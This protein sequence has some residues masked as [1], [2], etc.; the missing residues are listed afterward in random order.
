MVVGQTVGIFSRSGEVEYRW[1]SD[2]LS[3]F[4]TVTPFTITNSNF[5]AFCD[6]IYR[7]S[8]AILYHSRNRGRVNITDVTDSLY[9]EE[10]KLM[11][12]VLGKEHVIAVIDDL[13][14]SS[15]EA[16]NRILSHQHSLRVR[17]Q[18]IFL[19]TT[20]EKTNHNLLRRKVENIKS[21]IANG[22]TPMSIEDDDTPVS[23]SVPQD[24]MVVG[25]TVGIFSRSGEVEYRWLS[26]VLRG[27]W[28]VTPFTITN[29]NFPAFCDQI[30]RCSFAILYHSR[31]RGRVNITDVTDSLYDEEVTF[32]SEVLGKAHVIAVID[33]LDDSSD[34]AKHRILSHQHSLRVRTQDIFLVT[35]QEKANHNLLRRK[36]ENIR[37]AIANGL[38]PPPIEGPG[39]GPPQKKGAAM[40][41]AISALTILSFRNAYHAPNYRNGLLLIFWTSLTLKVLSFRVC[42]PVLPLG[43]RASLL[44][45]STMAVM[46]IY[47]TWHRPSA[48]HVTGSLLWIICCCKYFL[49]RRPSSGLVWRLIPYGPVLLTLWKMWQPSHVET[50]LQAISYFV[51]RSPLI[52]AAEGI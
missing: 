7:C 25:Q 19:V 38:R 2:V 15:D 3:G 6:Q 44:L 11:S 20:Q 50:M 12:E 51:V 31:N 22:M 29:S 21:I 48:L 27:F 18:D 26:D 39:E 49:P 14:D 10:V 37:S 36:I 43:S 46:S 34:E 35:T 42:K 45:S 28:T 1:L 4:W 30:Y 52:L 40:K 16:K 47:D 33:D 5:P 32:M 13:D 9:D 23:V 24:I 17:T 8:F 41:L